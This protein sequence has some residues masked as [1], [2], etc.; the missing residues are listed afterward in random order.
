VASEAARLPLPV[1]RLLAGTS[2]CCVAKV[3]KV[4]FSVKLVAFQA[5]VQLV[6]GMAG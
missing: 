1:A 6:R 5:F 2:L 3:L 4:G